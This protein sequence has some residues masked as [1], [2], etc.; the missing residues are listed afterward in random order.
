MLS[1]K[2]PA[3]LVAILI[4][5]AA[6]SLPKTLSAQ[7]NITV[8]GQDITFRLG[9]TLQPRFTYYASGY[10]DDTVEEIG[11]GVRRMRFRTYIGIGPDLA[12]FTQLEGSGA[13]VQMLDLRLEYKLNPEWTIRTGRFVGAQPRAMGRTLHNDIDAI[14][15]I[16]IADYWARNSLGTDSR[17]YGLELVYRPKFLEYRLFIHN[18]DN[19]ENR[20]TG[21]SETLPTAN[22]KT[23]AISSAVSYFPDNDPHT[24]IGVFIGFNGNEGNY[25]A[26]KSYYTASFHAY[27][28]TFPGHFPFRVKLDAILL[29]HQEVQDHPER[30]DHIFMGAS[31]FGGYLLRKDTEVFVKGEAYQVDKH[32]T[33]QDVS[34]LTAGLTYSFSAAR[35]K[36]FQMNKITAAYNY[37]QDSI[38]DRKAGIFQIQMQVLL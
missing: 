11:F 25:S 6:F 4:T 2:Q 13:N 26:A 28:G 33:K 34:I 32:I 36:N 16:A 23:M 1:I 29:R 17:D 3:L 30:F 27:R 31:L 5:I 21:T 9:A 24:D 37:K 22:K 35:D 19:R 14:D 15:R 8:A 20:K 7:Q 18:G 12:L 10:N 38:G